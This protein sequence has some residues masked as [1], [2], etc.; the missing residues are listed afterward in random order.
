MYNKTNTMNKEFL[1][2]QKIAGLITENQYER[3]E[4]NATINQGIYMDF[5]Q[6]LFDAL[7]S[8]NTPYND[9]EQTPKEKALVN[10]IGKALMDAGITTI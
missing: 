10:A 9:E 8:N 4:E 2:M 5:L 1:K 7:G 6:D 3:D